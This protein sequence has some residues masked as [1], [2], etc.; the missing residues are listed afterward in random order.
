MDNIKN[1]IIDGVEYVPYEPTPEG[2]PTI[3]PRLAEKTVDWTFLK[4][5]R[6]WSAVIASVSI[7]LETKGIIGEPERN[8]ISII[9]ASF[10]AVGTLDR[11]G[12]SVSK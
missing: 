6:F 5:T 1:I 12:Q 8:L 3:V 2:A 7:Y 11:L 4:S 10:V 9:A